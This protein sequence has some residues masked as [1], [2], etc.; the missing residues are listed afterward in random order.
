MGSLTYSQRLRADVDQLPSRFQ[1]VRSGVERY[2]KSISCSKQHFLV[3]RFRFLAQ[4]L[5]MN[6]DRWPAIVDRLFGHGR[7]KAEEELSRFKRWIENK[8]LGPVTRKWIGPWGFRLLSQFLKHRGA[9]NWELKHARTRAFEKRW[10]ALCPG[11]RSRLEEW[12]RAQR[13]RNLAESS[14]VAFR[15]NLVCL[16]EYLEER[17]LAFDR[18]DYFDAL[19]WLET[20]RESDIAPSW[21][22]A[23]LSVVKRFYRWLIARQVVRSSPFEEFSGA[24]I[25]RRLPAIL[26]EEEVVRLIAGA[27]PGRNRAIVEVLYAS[28]CRAGEIGRMEL[29]DISLENRTIKTKGKGGH[30]RIAF[31]NRSAVTAIRDYLPTRASDAARLARVD[32]RVLFLNY[33]GKPLSNYAV[34]NVVKDAARAAKL[35]H[36]HPHMLRHS[37]ATHLL[38]RGADLFSIMQFLGHKSIQT[39]V[40]YLQVATARLSEVHRKYHP[41]R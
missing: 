23:R 39:T 19:R 1:R 36:V 37:F 11:F 16:G 6:P 13:A 4:S 28:G 41:R 38:D 12:L 31:L 32:E 3:C 35:K 26:S 40:K 21:V 10:G 27:S 15:L 34:R 8:D 14:L 17:R 5:R 22:N 24:N 20:L 25:P 7:P 18:L 2:L 29:S 30:E 9:I 33:K